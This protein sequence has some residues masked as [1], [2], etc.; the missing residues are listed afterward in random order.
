[1]KGLVDIIM[2]VIGMKGLFAH[3]LLCGVLVGDGLVHD[4]FAGFFHDKV[5]SLS[6][7]AVVGGNVYNGKRKVNCNDKM[8]MSMDDI[9]ECVRSIKIKNCEGYDRIPQRILVDDIGYLALP[10]N[11]LFNEIYHTNAIPNQWLIAEVC[12]IYPQISHV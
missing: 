3:P 5:R 1:M 12:P 10:L 9:T 4:S 6:E 11:H 2:N 8:F 7:Q